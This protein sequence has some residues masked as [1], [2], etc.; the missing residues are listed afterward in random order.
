MADGAHPHPELEAAIAAVAAKAETAIGKANEAISAYRALADLAARVKALEDKPAPAPEPTPPPVI[1][2]APT[3]DLPPGA[4]ILSPGQSIVA[5]AKAG[6]RILALRTGTWN[7]SFGDSPRQYQDLQ[8]L[9]IPGE[10]PVIDGTGR[11]PNFLYHGGGDVL[12]D[13][14][15]RNFRPVNSGVLS[16]N[17][18][19]PGTLTLGPHFRFTMAGPA[20]RTV[21]ILYVDGSGQARIADGAELLDAADAAVQLY[22]ATTTARIE[23][24]RAKLSGR[25]HTIL[26]YS[27]GS[28]VLAGTI[29]A[30]PTGGVA[31]NDIRIANGAVVTGIETCRGT[32][33]N[34]AVR[35]S[36]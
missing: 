2:P 36:R 3:P 27:R 10:T 4:V 12:V 34:G 30:N 19:R 23:I 24:G 31:A 18:E 21:H 14:P 15:L 6:K 26:A 32:G 33:P 1:V 16:T 9:T 13:V 7:E 25:T 20:E 8:L 29:F 17:G 28:I 35:V 11:D 22:D 5:A